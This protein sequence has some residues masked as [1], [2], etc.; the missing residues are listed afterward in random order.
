MAS[1]AGGD[2][3]PLAVAA[4]IAAELPG[5]GDPFALDWGTA[6]ALADQA[7]DI[8]RQRE[9]RIAIEIGAVLVRA[10]SQRR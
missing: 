9:R 5:I 10:F 1:G 7:R 6:L 4:L 3:A 2:G 8:A